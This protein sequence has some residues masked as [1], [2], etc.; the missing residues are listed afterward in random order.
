MSSLCSPF[1]NQHKN[2]SSSRSQ[3]V[4]TE[5]IT[6]LKIPFISKKQRQ[7][8]IN[9]HS[10]TNLSDKIRLIFTTQPSLA[11]QFRK[12]REPQPCSASCPSCPS[13]MKVNQCFTKNAIYLIKCLTCDSIYIGQTSKCMRNLIASMNIRVG[14]NMKIFEFWLPHLDFYVERSYK[15]D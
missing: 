14:W 2:S 7:Q 10:S 12:S 5:P 11:W 3:Q 9:L 13:S 8:I 1:I 4:P 6:T 15:L